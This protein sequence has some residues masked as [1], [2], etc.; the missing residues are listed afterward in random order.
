[1]LVIP[2]AYGNDADVQTLNTIG[3]TSNTRYMVAAPDTI[4][5]LLNLINSF[6]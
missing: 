6:F 3:R 5:D 4:R 1:V 2:I